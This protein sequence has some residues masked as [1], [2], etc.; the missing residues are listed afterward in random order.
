MLAALATAAVAD[1]APTIARVVNFLDN[2]I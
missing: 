2:F 1:I